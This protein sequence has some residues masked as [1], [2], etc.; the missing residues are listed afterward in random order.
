M[1]N[2]V[3][4]QPYVINVSAQAGSPVRASYTLVYIY[5]TNAT[6]SDGLLFIT[7]PPND[8][9]VFS[10]LEVCVRTLFMRVK[11]V[12]PDLKSFVLRNFVRLY[13]HYGA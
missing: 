4:T 7:Q 8:G 11:S 1:T 5:V 13:M 3:R 2:Y 10:V 9:A 12:M 6:L